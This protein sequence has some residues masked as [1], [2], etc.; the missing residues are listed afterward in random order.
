[1]NYWID[2]SIK[3][4]QA[5]SAKSIK[6]TEKQLKKYYGDTMEKI[7]GQ[8][9]KTYN[10][11]LLSMS[12]GKE[13]TVADLYKLDTYWQMQGQLRQELQKLGDKQISL[14]SK[15]FELHFFDIYYSFAVPG[16]EA[17]NTIDIA[18]VQQLINQIWVADGQSWSQRVWSNTNKLQQALNDN[19][20]SAVITGAKSGELKKLLMNDFNVSYERA[21]S[22]VRTEIAHIQTQAA[23]KRYEDYGIQEVEVLV[24]EDEKTCPICS[25]LDGKRVPIFG[26]MPVPA[27]PRCRCAIIP[28]VD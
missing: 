14:L 18:V 15:N 21:D 11:I 23:Q 16:E 2:R 10:K 7:L 8:F 19:L 3:A 24:D 5:L 1:M 6:Q 25:K 28:V 27:H 12:E 20:M 26:A 4:Q 9:E 13:P 22:L 17:F